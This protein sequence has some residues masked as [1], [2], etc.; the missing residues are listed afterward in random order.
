MNNQKYYLY[1]LYL[2][3]G[4]TCLQPA[5]P[6]VTM[7]EHTTRHT[8]DRLEE[9]VNRLTQGFT[10]LSQNYTIFSQ[11]QS[12]LNSKLDSILDCLVVLTPAPTSPKSPPPDTPMPTPL[13][14]AASHLLPSQWQPLRPACRLRLPWLL[15][16]SL[17]CRQPCFSSLRLS[18]SCSCDG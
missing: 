8:I 16:T 11:A 10:T 12:I 4:L 18:P 5:L 7:P 2:S 13:P 9:V 15:P 1:P 3:I 17:P 14:M 6:T